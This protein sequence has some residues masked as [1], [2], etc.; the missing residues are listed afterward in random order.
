MVCRERQLKPPL[1][2][3]DEFM[4]NFTHVGE[5]E[6]RPQG[7]NGCVICRNRAKKKHLV[8]VPGIGCRDSVQL[9]GA[10]CLTRN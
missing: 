2:F 10:P 3:Q 6:Q 1:K 5:K 7:V 9:L 4:K 8:A